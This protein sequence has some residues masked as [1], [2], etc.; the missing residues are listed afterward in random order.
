MTRQLR[1]TTWPG[2]GRSRCRKSGRYAIEVARLDPGTWFVCADSNRRHRSRC[3]STSTCGSRGGS[4][5]W[6][7]HRGTGVR[8]RGPGRV[9]ARVGPIFGP[10]GSGTWSRPTTSTD[11]E[12]CRPRR[13]VGWRMALTRCA[14]AASRRLSSFG[15]VP[16]KAIKPGGGLA[17]AL[18]WLSIVSQASDRLVHP[19]EVVDRLWRAQAIGRDVQDYLVGKDASIDPGAIDDINYALTPMSVRI[20]QEKERALSAYTVMALQIV[21]DLVDRAETRTC[22]NEKC[23]RVFTRQRGRSQYGEHRTKGV[24]FCSKSCALAQTQR[25][26][27]RRLKAE[28][29]QSNG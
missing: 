4:A 17:H 15:I 27:R 8:A 11:T 20:I 23:G 28:K 16:A 2:I 22:R 13:P 25:E 21:N 3:R 24:Q 19:V 9:R 18:N 10:R 14:A 26:R 7:G 29:V 12:R 1:M 5:R 6:N